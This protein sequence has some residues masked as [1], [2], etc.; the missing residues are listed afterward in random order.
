VATSPVVPLS[1]TRQTSPA[2]IS[3]RRAPEG[4]LT[5]RPA[6]PAM[7]ADDA[8]TTRPTRTTGSP[9][10]DGA[11]RMVCAAGGAGAG[12]RGAAGPGAGG[13][14]GAGLGGGADGVQLATTTATAAAVPTTTPPQRATTRR[15][16]RSAAIV[17]KLEL[18][19]EILGPQERDDRL[20]LVA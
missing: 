19:P 4:S 8:P 5:L 2:G 7:V 3:A 17:A 10:P 15:P 11:G 9:V 1:V 16:R 14:A 6:A 13:A 20:Q 12:A 18:D